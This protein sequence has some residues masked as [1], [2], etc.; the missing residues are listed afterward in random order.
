[1]SRHRLVTAASIEP[2]EVES[3]ELH[4]PTEWKVF[5]ETTQGCQRK[6]LEL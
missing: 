6:G 5:V 3:I 4:S 2:F 1:M